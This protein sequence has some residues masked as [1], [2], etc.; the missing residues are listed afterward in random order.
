MVCTLPYG[1]GSIEVDIPEANLLYQALPHSPETIEPPDGLIAAALDHPVGSLPLEK[2]ARPG[3][4]VAL[5]VDDLTRPTPKKLLLPHVLG[6]LH[7]AGVADGDIRLMLALGTH[8]QMTEAEIDRHIGLETAR[9]YRLINFDYQDAS[10]FVSLGDTESGIPVEVYRVLME[11][12]FRVALGNIVPHIAA[13]WGGG[14]KA[15]QPGMCSERTTEA[16]HLIACTEQDVLRVCGNADNLCR[17]EI[18]AIAGRVGLDFIINTVMDEQERLRG[19]FCGHFVKAHRAG[20]AL[21]EQVLCPPIPQ[22]ADIVIASANPA[23][24]DFW[25]GCKPYI[26]A[27]YGVRRGGVLLFALHAEEGLCGNAF[28]HEETLARYGAM[29][30]EDIR[31][32]VHR[33][34]VTDVVGINVPLFLARLRGRVRTI[35]VSNGISPR[36]AEQLGFESAPNLQSALDRAFAALGREASVGVIPYAGETLVRLPQPVEP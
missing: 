8:R 33:G 27:Q 13:G 12:D 16:T 34:E 32:A 11:T 3:M 10:Q 30:F 9:R 19:V 15:I 22:P 36:Q 2:L 18:E 5:L 28:H 14:A 4:R 31:A 24:V 17:R 26:F 35:L 1:P 25:Q 20:V 23:C 21:A 6:R 7:Q 29:S